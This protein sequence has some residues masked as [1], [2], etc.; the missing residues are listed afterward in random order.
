MKVQSLPP[1]D[2]RRKI[3]PVGTCLFS[4][5]GCFPGAS[6]LGGWAASRFLFFPFFFTLDKLDRAGNTGRDACFLHSHLPACQ[7]PRTQGI[8]SSMLSV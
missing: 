2:N 7:V 3:K 1:E 5:R 8:L 4:G 6:G